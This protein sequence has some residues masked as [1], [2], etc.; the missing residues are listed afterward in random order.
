[1]DSCAYPHRTLDFEGP[2]MSFN[3]IFDAL[4]AVSIPHDFTTRDVIGKQVFLY[5]LGHATTGIGH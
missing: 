4:H 1:M 2:P 3:G 5:L